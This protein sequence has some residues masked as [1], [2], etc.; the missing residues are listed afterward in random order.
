MMRRDFGG[1]S[2][3]VLPIRMRMRKQ[4]I[5]WFEVAM[6]ELPGAQEFESRGELGKEMT[7]DEIDK[8]SVD[9]DEWICRWMGQ[10]G[11][12][13]EDCFLSDELGKIA[14]STVLHDEMYM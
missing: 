8:A 7:G 11:L 4:Q 2:R 1:G 9:I 6:N 10:V 5:K 12:G 3:D 14:E 13:A